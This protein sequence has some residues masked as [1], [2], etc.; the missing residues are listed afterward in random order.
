MITIKITDK[1]TPQ[2]N[3]F[4]DEEWET[5][6]LQY[7]RRKVDWTKERRF[8]LA[9]EKKQ[10]V[11]L[12]E[13][14]MEAGVMHIID[15][16]IEHTHQKKGIGTSLMEHAEEMAKQNKIHKIFLE[17]GG[18]WTVRAFYEKLGYEKTGDLPKHFAKQDYVE[19]SKFI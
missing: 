8:I 15:L 11:G 14:S 18:N 19:Y 3:A 7:H 1:E 10:I 5:T 4:S 17:T 16:I 13:L 2:F 6:D 12:L 9:Y